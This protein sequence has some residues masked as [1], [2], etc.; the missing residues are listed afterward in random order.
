MADKKSKKEIPDR[1]GAFNKGLDSIHNK[2]FP[3]SP[4]RDPNKVRKSAFRVPLKDT[5]NAML[6]SM[7]GDKEKPKAGPK[8]YVKKGNQM[9]SGGKVTVYKDGGQVSRGG[10]YKGAK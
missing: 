5:A 8:G 9:K 10:K 3:N 6:E 1:V 7:F 2:L 4:S